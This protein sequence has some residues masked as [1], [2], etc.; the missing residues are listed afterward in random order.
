M[1]DSRRYG[2]EYIIASSGPDNDNDKGRQVPC[3]WTIVTDNGGQGRERHYS[4]LYA[5]LIRFNI[6]LRSKFPRLDA[7][8]SLLT[9][10]D[11]LACICLII[12]GQSPHGS[13]YAI[14]GVEG[15]VF[16][17]LTKSPC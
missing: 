16:S 4:V 17:G 12:R 15:K 10:L 7:Q 11:R 14:M 2:T 13:V 1:S 8:L 3:A 5:C 9:Y 6:A